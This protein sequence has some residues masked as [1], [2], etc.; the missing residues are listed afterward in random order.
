MKSIKNKNLSELLRKKMIEQALD[1]I[2]KE[3]LK[4]S[5]IYT[6]YILI[7]ITLLFIFYFYCSK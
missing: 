7:L 5:I 3:N 1:N 4:S 2:P 6:V